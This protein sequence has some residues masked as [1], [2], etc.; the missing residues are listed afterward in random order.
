MKRDDG[1]VQRIDPTSHAVLATI[2]AEACNGI[3]TDGASIWTCSGTDLV[4][5]DPATNTV[6]EVVPVRKVF[7]Q[8]RL[9]AVAGRIWILTGESAEQ[10]VG[11]DVVSEK[12]GLPIALAAA[13]WDLAAGGGAV[14]AACPPA[15]LV[16]RIDP[17]TGIVSDRITVATP[18][19]ISVGSDAVWVGSS[20]GLVR[21]GLTDRVPKVVVKG[22]IPGDLGSV[23]A[24]PGAIWVRKTAPFLTRVDPATSR[25]IETITAPDYDGGGDVIGLG[26][27]LWASAADNS[28]VVHLRTSAP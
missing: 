14:W 19:Q 8:G 27:E 3:G 25:I 9:V 15:N 20:E 24:S 21:I 2:Q 17:A 7:V 6:V 13:C 28:I 4:R 1:Q 10:L 5:I 11:F 23:W 16:L 18:T 22:L 26:D 12:V